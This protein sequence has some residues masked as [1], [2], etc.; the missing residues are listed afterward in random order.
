MSSTYKIT[1][2]EE[3]YFYVSN[4]SLIST[5]NVDRKRLKKTNKYIWVDQFPFNVCYVVK[6]SDLPQ[7]KEKASLFASCNSHLVS[8]LIR[9]LNTKIQNLAQVQS[10]MKCS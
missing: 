2:F 4:T 1:N 5:K 7:M 9:F 3:E 6:Y 8:K 10:H